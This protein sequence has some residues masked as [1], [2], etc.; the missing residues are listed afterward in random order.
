MFRTS[1]LAALLAAGGT[2]PLFSQ[3]WV[4]IERQPGV[5]APIS[6]IVRTSSQVR[7]TVEGRVA[8]VEVEEQFRNTGGGVAEGT[9]LYPMPGEA[10]FTDFSLWMGEQEVRGE[11]MQAEQARG[12]YEEIVRRLRDPALLTLEGHGLIRARVFPIAPGETRKVVLR[13]TQMLDRSGDA[14]RLRYA[15][16]NRSQRETGHGD[17]RVQPGDVFSFRVTL[18]DAST[19]GTPYS[20]THQITTRESAGRLVVTLTLPGT[21]SCSFR[22]GG[23]WSAP[24][25]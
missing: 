9:Y 12:I 2:A 4:D 22:S 20:P 10:V 18:P 25:W 11:M 5:V 13:Y 6:S 24:A 21:W 3:G 19:M 1:I 15:I 17:V 14:L 7:V 8:R 23:G 16:G